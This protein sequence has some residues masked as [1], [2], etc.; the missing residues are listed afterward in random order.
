MFYV[1]G[2]QVGILIGKDGKNI[3]EVQS[4]TNTIIKVPRKREDTN[5]SENVSV[6]IRGNEENQKK[7][8]FKILQNLKQKIEKH[9]AMSET[10]II[11]NSKIAGLVI[12]KNGTNRKLIEEMTGA[13]LKI[14][15]PEAGSNERERK[16]VIRGT[17]E[18][19]EEAKE[20]VELAMRG[21]DIATI[22]V[23]ASLLQKLLKY[24]EE[25]GF[26]FPDNVH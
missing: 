18:Q 3:Q 14:I 8:L 22:V 17:A 23:A 10:M 12:G 24:F 21:E 19:I 7:A 13:K 1:P 11:P 6:S 5:I 20:F 2:D 15:N 16:C 9:I 25:K 4:E 26:L